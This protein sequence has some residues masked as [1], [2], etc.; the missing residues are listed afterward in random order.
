MTSFVYFRQRMV[1]SVRSLTLWPS[2]GQNGLAV[3]EWFSPDSEWQQL[4]RGSLLLRTL[5]SNAPSVFI[6]PFLS[7]PYCCDR[8]YVNSWWICLC[9][10]LHVSSPV[11]PAYFVWLSSLTCCVALALAPSCR[12]HCLLMCSYSYCL[13]V[14]EKV[15]KS[16]NGKSHLPESSAPLPNLNSGIPWIR[17]HLTAIF[18]SKIL[19]TSNNRLCQPVTLDYSLDT[20]DDICAMHSVTQMKLS[21]GNSTLIPH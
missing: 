15:F 14:V 20:L 16:F 8:Y 18:T 1:P 21:V 10:S 12:C 19:K 11:F 2:I 4:G 6:I 5:V 7:R 17:C 9:L 13:P 3:V